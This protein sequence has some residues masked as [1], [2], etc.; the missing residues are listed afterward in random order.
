MALDDIIARLRENEA[1]L[2]ARRGPC[3]VVRLARPRHE[4]AEDWHFI[5]L[6][7]GMGMKLVVRFSDSSLGLSE[8]SM[9]RCVP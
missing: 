2:R 5:N 1:A 8:G 7:A 6:Q 9:S 4:H 3:R